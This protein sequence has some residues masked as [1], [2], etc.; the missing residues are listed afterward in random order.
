M[1]SDPKQDGIGCAILGVL[2]GMVTMAAVGSW[3]CAMDLSRWQRNAVEA[4]H[5]EYVITDPAT[6]ATEFRWKEEK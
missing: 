1:A 2:V 3:F 6:G 4:G 5:A